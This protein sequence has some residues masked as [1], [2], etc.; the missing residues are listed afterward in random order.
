M[1][2]KLLLA[3]LF[4]PLSVTLLPNL[5]AGEIPTRGENV[6]DIRK[7]V[8]GFKQTFWLVDTDGVNRFQGIFSVHGSGIQSTQLF[9]ASTG[10]SKWKLRTYKVFSGWLTKVEPIESEAGTMLRVWT[11]KDEHF[12]IHLDYSGKLALV[13]PKQGESGR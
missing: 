8:R 10:T 9:L 1:K 5:Q 7:D 6:E 12:D 11:R 2:P 3:G 13:I 4:L